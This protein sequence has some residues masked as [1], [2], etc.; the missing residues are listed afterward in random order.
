MKIREV[1]NGHTVILTNEEHAF[2]DNHSP[3]LSINSL[4]DRDQWIARNLVRK[5]VYEISKDSQHIVLKTNE[6]NPQKFI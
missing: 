2:I 3:K 6:N 1:I 5:G 4:H